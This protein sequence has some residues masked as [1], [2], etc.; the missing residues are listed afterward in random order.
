MRFPLTT[1]QS[2]WLAK[3][4]GKQTK[5]GIL[6]SAKGKGNPCIVVFGAGPEGKT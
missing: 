1:E 2:E 5:R 4:S 3:Q 6:I